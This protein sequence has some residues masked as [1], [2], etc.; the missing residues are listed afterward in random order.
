MTLA[1]RSAK[2]LTPVLSDEPKIL[3]AD[4][5]DPERSLFNPRRR[6]RPAQRFKE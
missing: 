6:R 4:S 3:A 2:L 1:V 5:T